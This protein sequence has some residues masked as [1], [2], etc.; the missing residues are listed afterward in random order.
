MLIPP[1]KRRLSV[2]LLFVL[3]FLITGIFV[4]GNI[5][6]GSKI[7]DIKKETQE[8]LSSVAYL[9]V[10]RIKTWWEERLGDAAVIFNDHPM[11]LFLNEFLEEKG[12]T[13]SEYVKKEIIVWMEALK[14]SANYKDIVLLDTKGAVK[15]ATDYQDKT[16]CPTL[17]Q[18]I[19]EALRTKNIVATDLYRC[20][21]HGNIDIDIVI[22]LLATEGDRAK[23]MGLMVL[24][25]N[26]NQFLYPLIQYYPT[27]SRTAETL[28]VRRQDDHV[29]Y[30]NELRHLKDTAL[31]LTLPLSNSRLTAA[32]A[33]KGR[34]GIIEG[35]DYRGVKVLCVAQ[36]VPNTPWYLIAK[37]DESEAYSPIRHEVFRVSMTAFL[38]VIISVIFIALVWNQQVTKFYR[39][40]YEMENMRIKVEDDLRKANEEWDRTFDA[41]SDAI[42]I[43]NTD[44]TII[45]GNK[46][47]FEML[48]VKS[49]D[50]I[51]KTC[52]EVMHKLHK[53]WPD[54]PL[55]KTKLD[56]RPH[57]EEVE[58]PEIGPS[59][60]ISTSPI[61]DDKGKLFGAVHI[62]RN[63]TERKRTERDLKEA[64]E[65]LEKTNKELRKLDQL[66]S[67]FIST[68]SHEL[69]TPLAIIKE[70]INLILD[71][72]PGD[73]NE[74]QFK[75]LDV[76]RHNIDRL[77]RIIN[78]LLDISK[79]EAGK[80]ELKKAFVSI[81]DVINQ[82]ISAFANK[83]KQKELEL[84]LDIDSQT[85]KIYVDADRIAQVVTNLLDNAIKFTDKGYIQIS[86]K[87]KKDF[88]ECSVADTGTGIS[89]DDLPKVFDKF[90]QF[91]RV[92]GAG[93]K[94]T[95]LGL[96]IAKNILDMHN[97]SITI[98]S[99]LGKGTKFTFK[100]HKYTPENLFNKSAKDAIREAGKNGLSVSII[101]VS[102]EISK[103]A[104]G[105]VSIRKMHEAM[106]EVGRLVKSTL[107]RGGD[108]VVRNEGDILVI[109]TDC[110]KQNSLRVR[111]KVEGIMQKYLSDHEMAGIIKL[112]FGCATYPEDATD[113]MNL[114][115]KAKN[116]LDFSKKA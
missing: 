99:E 2:Y 37:I 102:S 6:I 8:N 111:N 4:G 75:I 32:M 98:E 78:S 47:L 14:R 24:R 92:A 55:E 73:I 112:R 58:D 20:N 61:F 21:L 56:S 100:L 22:P 77:A 13:R 15:L 79:I 81:S 80:V 88:I 62:S 70:G 97:G 115:L 54:C 5:Y 110:D 17:Q 26:P 25:I 50:V 44:H 59:L 36:K 19:S 66:K 91:G 84:R 30:L 86:C 68:V 28:L 67:D 7:K 10:A 29:L 71:K 27:P 104:E 1:E 3:I 105:E 72:I 82:V 43:V 89:K 52:H 116:A 106:A 107:N 34:E 23:P 41:I 33:A 42:F 51:G 95:G 12:D 65:G 64:K 90:Q 94:G 96:S 63:I 93:D 108:D 16:I 87:D 35:V 85:D 40:R 31:S 11:T 57:T 48:G 9:K 69:R 101:M 76:S 103:V 53:P 60:L 39:V 45:K 74:K 38:L 49:E 109:L 18:F 113:E 46:A 114:V 83:I